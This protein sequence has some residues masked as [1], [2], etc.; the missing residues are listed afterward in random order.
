MKI[1]VLSYNIHKGFTA[2]GSNFV[3]DKIKSAIL[4]VKADL[5]LLQEVQGEH[6]VYREKISS[7]PKQ[8]QFEYLADQTW[9]HH[10][11]G[12]NAVY[13]EGHHG[14]AILSKYPILTS[15]NEDISYTSYERRGLLHATIQLPEANSSFEVVCT[16]LGLFE[17]DRHN[18]VNAL[19]KRV[20]VKVPSNSPLLVAG[21]FND[22]RQSLSTK[23]E[24]DLQ[25]H[26]VFVSQASEH[27]KTFP[28][29][30][31]MLALDRIY[32]RGM[33]CISAELLNGKSWRVLSDHLP[34]LAEFEIGSS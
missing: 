17:K 20:K 10:A 21:D 33:K 26:E 13:S 24:T 6:H 18:Q 16:H 25:M 28:S 12:K 30:F 14:N 31:P 23:F 7:W 5:V 32:Y 1:R 9:E 4:A 22:W 29:W 19:S 34:I 11:Y 15:E 2:Y 27:V 8:T 3:L